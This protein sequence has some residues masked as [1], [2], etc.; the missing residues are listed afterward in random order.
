MPFSARS[1]APS[2]QFTISVS[3]TLFIGRIGKKDIK[4]L[5]PFSQTPHSRFRIRGD[6]LRPPF[7]SQQTEV[8][9]DG[10]DQAEIFFHEDRRACPS[11]QGF[12]SDISA[13]GEKIEK[14]LPF[15]GDPEY[16]KATP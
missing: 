4:P 10:L 5:S 6:H 3:E 9:P 16:Q 1:S 15:D 8:L 11:A 12:Q 13:A 7:K 2:S 14:R